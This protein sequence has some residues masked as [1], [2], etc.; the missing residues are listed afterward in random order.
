MRKTIKYTNVCQKIKMAWRCNEPS[1][2]LWAGT[3][4]V[5]APGRPTAAPTATETHSRL[6]RATSP[7]AP[8]QL[9]GHY[10][11]ILVRDTVVKTLICLLLTIVKTMEFVFFAICN[12]YFTNAFLILYLFAELG[13]D[14]ET[15]SSELFGETRFCR[16]RDNLI[17]VTR[18]RNCQYTIKEAVITTC[19]RTM[20]WFVEKHRLQGGPFVW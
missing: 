18:K 4:T 3:G 15:I 11:H 13:L 20:S 14:V 10:I 2:S 16:L 8:T 1:S 5:T 6:T 17:L 9:V 7:A 12:V 19:T